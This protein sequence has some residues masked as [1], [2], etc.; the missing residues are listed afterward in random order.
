VPSRWKP[1]LPP[2][3]VRAWL[4]QGFGFLLLLLVHMIGMNA[5]SSLERWS[6]SSLTTEQ[7]ERAGV[8]RRRFSGY[9]ALIRLATLAAAVGLGVW[10][11]QQGHSSNPLA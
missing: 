7:P 4:E 1:N 3:A 11:W 9:R 10:L 2:I 5:I 6:V 8:V